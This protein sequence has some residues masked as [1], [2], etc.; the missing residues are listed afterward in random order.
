MRKLYELHKAFSFRTLWEGDNPLASFQRL[1]AESARGTGRLNGAVQLTSELMKFK[2]VKDKAEMCFTNNI[3]T[4]GGRKWS[5][6][7]VRD[8]MVSQA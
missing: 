7:N 5:F 1:A 8:K 3:Y 6:D 4:T 2:K